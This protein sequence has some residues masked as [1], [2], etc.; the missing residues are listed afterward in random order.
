MARR[1]IRLLSV[2][3]LLFLF[4]IAALPRVFAIT[5]ADNGATSY[6]IVIAADA[7]ASEEH[8]AQELQMF[9]KMISG[10]SL[11]VCRENEDISGSAIFVGNSSKLRSVDTSIDFDR[12][13]PDGFVM[14]TAGGNLILAGGRTR[15]SMYAVYA[16]LEEKLGCR[17]YTSKVSHI[18]KMATVSIDRLNE[19]RTPAFES[20][21]PFWY[22]AFDGDWSARNRCNGS[23]A[24]L[25]ARRGGKIIYQGGH[26]F[27]RFIPAHGY[28]EDHPEYF[29][30]INGRRVFEQYEAQICLTNPDVIGITKHKVYAW[31]KE[32]PDVY[33]FG[34]GQNDGWDGHCDCPY[35][36][37]I[38]I[39]EESPSGNVVYF[40]NKVAEYVELDFPDKKIGTF[41]YNYTV[42]PPKYARPRNNVN[43]RLCHMTD[44][45]GCDAHPVEDCSHNRRF[46]DDVR[47][48]H[49]IA[50]HIY[51]WDYKT[52]FQHY[53]MPKPSFFATQKDLQFFRRMGVDG[54]MNQGAYQDYNGASAELS[55]YIEAKLMWD[56]DR[57]M[58]EIMN[59]F[60]TGYYGPAAPALQK[61][62]DLWYTKIFGEWEHFPINPQPYENYL[63]DAVLTKAGRYLDEAM[64]LANGNPEIE[65]RVEAAQLWIRYAKLNKP[66][67]HIAENGMYRPADEEAARKSLIELDD[68]LETCRKHTINVLEEYGTPR[69]KIM[70]ANFTAYP[71]VTLENEYLKV[72]VVPGLGGRILQIHNKRTGRNM[73]RISKPEVRYYPAPVGYSDGIL[74]YDRFEYRLE[75]TAAG[76]RLIMFSGG[77]SAT[78]FTSNSRTLHCTKEILLEAGKPEIMFT[79]RIEARGGNAGDLRISPTARFDMGACTDAR[80]GFEAESGVYEFF[81][82]GNGSDGNEFRKEYWKAAMPAGSWVLINEAENFGI[83]SVSTRSELD[84]CIVSGDA[85]SNTASLS[86]QGVYGSLRQGESRE[87]SH[88]LIFLDDVADIIK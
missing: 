61:Y 36:R 73:L 34:V 22:D 37:P 54:I 64:R 28:F 47:G 14:K 4:C 80:Y 71:I 13:G 86:L 5:L 63:S 33:I 3:S 46:A 45:Y 77:D 11:P 2:A 15:G 42:K 43:I 66:V 41:A 9:F 26:T 78:Y 81:S 48:W 62:Y 8:G 23:S 74:S 57:D 72:D 87:L 25:D 51:I 56:P 38:D 29:S 30:L 53:L 65:E 10:A 1:V 18:P 6:S 40:V 76:T 75:N 59:D 44:L 67:E 16:F 24:R 60:L 88:T 82:L 58:R 79:T 35:C 21:N 69:E 84:G 68:F 19:V 27:D 17:W 12:L 39:R 32:S 49:E 85:E 20:R 50:D 52:N 31:M 55:A 70:R 83:R 7:S